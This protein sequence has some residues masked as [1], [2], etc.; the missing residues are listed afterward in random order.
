MKAQIFLWMAVTLVFSLTGCLENAEPTSDK[1]AAI[2]FSINSENNKIVRFSSNAADPEIDARWDFGDGFTGQGSPI[3]HEYQ[4][5]GIYTVKLKFPFQGQIKLIEKQLTISGESTHITVTSQIPTFIDSDSNDPNVAFESNNVIPQEIATPAIASGILM[6]RNGCQAGRLCK[7]GDLIDQYL[8]HVKYGQQFRLSIL[9]GAIDVSLYDSQGKSVFT[10]NRLESLI[11]FDQNQ[12][13]QDDYLLTLA[14]PDSIKHAQYSFEIFEQLDSGLYQPG[15]LIVLW[16]HEDKPELVDIQDPRLRPVHNQG[17]NAA[18]GFLSQ[19]KNVRSVSLNYLRFPSNNSMP[20]PTWQWPLQLQKIDSLWQPLAMRGQIPAEDTRVAVLDTGVYLAHA[21]FSQ[22]RIEDAFDFVSDPINSRDGDGWDDNPDDPGDAMQSYHGSHVTGI[23]AAQPQSNS[24]PEQPILGIAWGATIMPI[25]VLGQYGGTS[26]DLIQAMRYAAGLENDSH[27]K[28]S[29]PA[30]IINLSLG[31]S[32]FSAAE[33]ATINE[34]V[35]SGCIVVAAAGNDAM[36]YVEYPARYQNV[37]AVGAYDQAKRLSYYS[38]YGQQLDLL[39]PGGECTDIDCSGGITSLSANGA[40]S[41]GYDTRSASLRTLS[42]T[43]MATA[44]VSALFAIMRSYL[45]SLDSPALLRLI[46]EGALTQDWNTEGFDKYSGWGSLDSEKILNVMDTSSL[47]NH[48]LWT[49]QPNLYL[50]ENAMQTLSLIYRGVHSAPLS[51]AY[52]ASQL[53]V[54]MDKDSIRIKTLGSFRQTQTIEIKDAN[55]TLLTITVH[56]K[57]NQLIS[58]AQATHL[59]VT[60]TYSHNPVARAIREDMTWTAQLEKSEFNNS[61]Q[62]STD[63][64]YDG[65]YCEPGEFC[66]FTQQI[67]PAAVHILEGTILQN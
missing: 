63:I 20:Y 60:N 45:P 1:S 39:A 6:S 59:Y 32:S 53:D 18:R 30:D 12:L 61:I 16:E 19:Q 55:Q 47:S 41:G 7:E 36:D 31:G 67:N 43:S 13:G 22:L 49:P 3:R 23:I 11:Y 14:L 66:A 34:V 26:Y 9:E 62:V 38:N 17:I 48:G 40:L 15:K 51:L 54:I 29:K 35:N 25:R 52:D 64:D 2:T 27:K 42:G 5:P 65:I 4:N 28:P 56:L 33:Q 46:R 21:N 57:N 44:H 8:I 58:A 50:T 24:H 37:I 10:Q